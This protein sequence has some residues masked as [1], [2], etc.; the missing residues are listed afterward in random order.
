[1][2]SAFRVFL[3]AADATGRSQ[4]SL[5]VDVAKNYNDSKKKKK[6]L[7]QSRFDSQIRR[8]ETS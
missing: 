1:M 3:A 4:V 5:D 6:R 8:L 2:V 7:V